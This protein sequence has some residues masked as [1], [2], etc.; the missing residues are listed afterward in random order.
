[1]LVLQVITINPTNEQLDLKNQLKYN[2]KKYKTTVHVENNAPCTFG[3]GAEEGGPVS[4][5]EREKIQ[6]LIYSTPE[7]SSHL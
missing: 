3:Q 7:L 5:H 2:Y 6:N 4:Y 1:M